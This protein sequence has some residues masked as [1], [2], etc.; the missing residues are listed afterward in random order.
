VWARLGPTASYAELL[1]SPSS[2]TASRAFDA[3]SPKVV[4]TSAE[5]SS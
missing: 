1:H 5:L 3:V 4:A 2:C